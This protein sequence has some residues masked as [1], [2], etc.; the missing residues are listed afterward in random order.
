MRRTL[1]RP[2]GKIIQGQFLL[3]PV[4]H[5]ATCVKV[6]VS[7]R[8]DMRTHGSNEQLRAHGPRQYSRSVNI[9]INRKQRLKLELLSLT[10]IEIDIIIMI[11]H[12]RSRSSRCFSANRSILSHYSV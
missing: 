8:L 5:A 2:D 9:V 11:S 6:S 10:D 3:E 1:S 7:K 12:N 4:A